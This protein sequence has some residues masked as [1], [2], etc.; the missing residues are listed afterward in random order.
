[1]PPAH[2]WL[3]LRLEAPLASFGTTMVQGFGPVAEFPSVALLTGLAASAIGWSWRDT[4]ALQALQDSVIAAMR[5]DRPG[6]T[7][8]DL[9]NARLR[10]DDVA[11]TTGPL[12]ATRRGASYDGPH[13]RFRDYHED[14][15][16][17]V[18][19]RLDP[20][21]TDRYVPDLNLLAAAF[22]FPARPLYIGRKPCLP[23][24][25]LVAPEPDCW[26]A[27]PTAHAALLALPGPAR[28]LRAAWPPGEGPA[29]GPDVEAVAPVPGLRNW[30]LGLHTGS[31][32]LVH[33][34][35]APH[36]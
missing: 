4:Q 29:E 25:P 32:P 3:V 14:L 19:L 31:Y 6:R 10:A 15:L 7:R 22:R 18:V 35:V 28:R 17:Q 12:P 33:G 27:A 5:A 34:Y 36:A 24:A 26:I 9:Q 1:M 8:T 11:W 2:T 16:V 21:A 23:A 30:E 13:R 20:T